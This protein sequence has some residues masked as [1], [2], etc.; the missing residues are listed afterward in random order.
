MSCVQVNRKQQESGLHRYS[1]Q[2]ERGSTIKCEEAEA[3]KDTRGHVSCP[4]CLPD[5][6]Y[7]P[8]YA[9]PS[10]SVI[11]LM[12]IALSCRVG[13]ANYPRRSKKKEPPSEHVSS[14]VYS[15]STVSYTCDYPWLSMQWLLWRTVMDSCSSDRGHRQVSKSR[16]D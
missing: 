12:I 14:L 8:A 10:D 5:D 16:S 9:R 2:S 4:L 6:D 7:D 11:V 3:E 15:W 1:I 13:V